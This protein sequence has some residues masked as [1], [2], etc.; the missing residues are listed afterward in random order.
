M[1]KSF[2]QS[3]VPLYA[4]VAILALLARACYAWLAWKH[5]FF[6]DLFLDSQHYADI[7]ISIA[8]GRGAGDSAYVMSPL[9]PYFLSLFVSA[10]GELAVWWVRG[11]QMGAGVTSCLFIASLAK[12]YGGWGAAWLGGL[13]SAVYGPLIH[14]ETSILV[15]VMQGFTFILALWM[16]TVIRSRFV[17][18]YAQIVIWFF[19]GLLLGLAAG[20]RPVALLVIAAT[21]ALLLLLELW[22]Q[23]SVRKMLLP[24]FLLLLGS[25]C[26]VLPFTVRNY[27]VAKE[28]VL[29]SA[30]GGMNFWIGN[31]KNA[32]G[33]FNTP[34]DYGFHLDPIGV[35]VARKNTGKNLSQKEASHWWSERALADIKTDPFH[36]L[37]LYGRKIFLFFH[38][39]EIPQ[40]G[41][42]FHWFAK[43]AW[44]LQ[45]PLNALPLLLLT[46]TLPITLLLTERE[47]LLTVL[48][49]YSWFLIYIAG[50]SLFFI[51]GRYRTPIMP[52]VLVMASVHGAVLIKQLMAAR[53]YLVALVMIII[54][55]FGTAALSRTFNSSR[56]L[57]ESALVTGLVE[58]QRGM[59]AFNQKQFTEAE[60]WYRKS[61]AIKENA[62]TRGNLANALKA[63]G[64]I[65]EAEQEYRQ[66]LAVAPKDHVTWYNLANLYRDY[67]QDYAKAA[68]YYEK[69]L[70]L[71]HKFAEPYLN[72]ALLYAR[73]GNKTKAEQIVESGLISLDSS[74]HKIREQ[75]VRLKVE[76]ALGNKSR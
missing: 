59:A 60:Q 18:P 75:L 32:T 22:Q 66:V 42:D 27:V 50:I 69:S 55:L 71:N 61:L 76:L 28:F 1:N 70:A 36:W 34:P 68:E 23:K 41:N 57:P 3:P 30:Y 47:R 25:S 19:A 73:T 11:V 13:L 35:E 9:Y 39:R 53:T 17:H 51:T 54:L 52:I 26:T 7:A 38:P 67:K 33:L 62:I 20:F 45:F 64:R 24:C 49:P 46:L 40:L 56:W 6:P 72:L 10:D 74:Q 58:R 37:G 31:H 63:Q 29:L 4:S 14:Y 48:L 21:V 43:K 15:E 65:A 8:A 16:L 44:P 12:H 5:H 2:L